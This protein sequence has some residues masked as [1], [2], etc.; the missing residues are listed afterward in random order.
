[1]TVLQ[2]GAQEPHLAERVSGRRLGLGKINYASPGLATRPPAR[3]GNGGP[4]SFADIL[5]VVH[6][7]G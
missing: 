5:Q 2:L 1:M 3:F 6:F 7:P 4:R